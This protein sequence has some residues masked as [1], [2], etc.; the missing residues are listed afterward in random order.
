MCII[1][2]YSSV[3]ALASEGQKMTESRADAMVADGVTKAVTSLAVLS[4]AM[5]K[6]IE[7]RIVPQPVLRTKQEIGGHV[8]QDR[9][10]ST[11]GPISSTK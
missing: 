6:I 10:L 4:V 11:H 9:C 1:L 5:E 3:L 7:A 8:K 2:V